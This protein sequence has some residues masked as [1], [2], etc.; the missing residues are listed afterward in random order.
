MVM[1]KPENSSEFACSC[2][3]GFYRQVTYNTSIV[4]FSGWECLPCLNNMTS[5]PNATNYTQCFCSSGLYGIPLLSNSTLSQIVKPVAISCSS[6]A[7]M[8]QTKLWGMT[9]GI[10]NP[11]TANRDN[12]PYVAIGCNALTFWIQYDLMALVSIASVTF[13]IRNAN[14]ISQCR[15]IIAVSSNG[16]FVGEQQN[17]MDCGSYSANGVCPGDPGPVNGPSVYNTSMKSP[18]S[19]RYVR[20]YHG[21]NPIVEGIG[22]LQMTV[23]R[24]TSA[25]RCTSCTQNSYCPS[26]S[27]NQIMQCPNNTYSYL[28]ASSVSQCGCPMNAASRVTTNNC[29]C[30]AGFYAVPNATA[31]IGGW[32]CNACPTNLSSPEGST[33]LSQCV[34]AGGFYPTT[35]PTTCAQCT[36]G[37][38]CP[39]TSTLNPGPLLCPPGLASVDGAATCTL[40]CPPGFYCPGIGK[41]LECPAGTYSTGGAGMSCVTCEPGYFCN[42]PFQHDPCPVGFYC[43]SGSNAPVPCPPGSYSLGNLSASCTTCDPG[44]Y[45][46]TADTLIKCPILFYCPSGSVRPTPCDPGLYSCAGSPICTIACPPGGY[47]PGNGTV[48]PCPVGTFSNGSATTACTSCPEGFFCDMSLQLTA[49]GCV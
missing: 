29:T 32:Q 33:S 38:Y 4:P 44:Y 45:C 34:C 36:S 43:P 48:I 10:G 6:G 22:L 28:G 21:G 12:Y 39:F 5:L 35:S 20:W 13:K 2:N 49:A 31:P 9:D 8:S 7:A 27:V 30:N 3:A 1:P 46:P 26:K 24:A 19:A 11:E 17:I 23:Y 37:T 41:A 16:S 15:N 40:Q 25:Y 18:V 14:S 42:V 47:C